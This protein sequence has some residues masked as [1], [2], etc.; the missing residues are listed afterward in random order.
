MVGYRAVCFKS[1]C[2]LLIVAVAMAV[3]VRRGA[4]STAANKGLESCKVLLKRIMIAG[5]RRRP[6]SLERFSIY[7]SHLPLPRGPV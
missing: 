5:Q 4:R 7:I 2:C 1:V 3:A 6:S